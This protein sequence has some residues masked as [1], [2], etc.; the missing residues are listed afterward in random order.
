MTRIHK[1]RIKYTNNMKKKVSHIYWK[2]TIVL[3][4][5]CIHIIA[6]GNQNFREVL[7]G[8]GVAGVVTTTTT[9][10]WLQ[11]KVPKVA[12]SVQLTGAL[13]HG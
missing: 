11:P 4:D 3:Y 2:C 9:D 1:H 5:F 10:R 7:P 6:L 13:R 8:V 12:Q